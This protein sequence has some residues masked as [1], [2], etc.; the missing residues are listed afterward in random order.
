LLLRDAGVDD[1]T[2]TG[3]PGSLSADTIYL[4][5]ESS[6]GSGSIARFKLARAT[7]GRDWPPFPGK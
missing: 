4:L 7:N 3:T 6:G 5:S 2:L 1:G